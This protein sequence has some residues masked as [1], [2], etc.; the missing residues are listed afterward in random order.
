[1]AVRRLQQTLAVP[2]VFALDASGNIYIADTSN[3]RIRK[4]DA[5]GVI[6][7]VAGNGIPGIPGRRTGYNGR[8][9]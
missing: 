9:Q 5:S 8:P 3:N 7:T 4:V 6:T 2:G 1:M